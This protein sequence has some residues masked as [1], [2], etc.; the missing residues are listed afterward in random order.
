MIIL[1]KYISSVTNISQ[2]Y[3]RRRFDDEKMDANGFFF[4]YDRKQRNPTMFQYIHAEVY[5]RIPSER[6]E[7]DRNQLHHK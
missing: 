3:K 5:E 1:F 4:C 6:P 2:E 7:F